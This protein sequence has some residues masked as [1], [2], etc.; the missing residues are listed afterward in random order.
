[1]PDERWA[2]VFGRLRSHRDLAILALGPDQKVRHDEDFIFYNQPIA[3]GGAARLLGK[4]RHGQSTT[5]R[6]SL[7]LAALPHDVHRVVISINM[8][9]DHGRIC[10]AFQQALLH[11]ANPTASQPSPAATESTSS[12]PE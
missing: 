8:D 5:E 12:I 3:A 10:A 7:R 9:V 11:I 1:M 2:E 4:T 6:A